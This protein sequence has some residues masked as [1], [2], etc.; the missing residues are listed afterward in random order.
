MY[1]PGGQL[2]VALSRTAGGDQA[3][4]ETCGTELVIFKSQSNIETFGTEMD[5]AQL[6]SDQKREGQA[7]TGRVDSSRVWLL[8]TQ[9]KS[10]ML[11]VSKLSN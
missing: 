10:Q 6:G 2:Q 11:K 8:W 4:E 9:G 1:I 3:E 5:I 7:D